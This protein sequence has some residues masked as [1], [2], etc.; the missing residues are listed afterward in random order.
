MTEPTEPKPVLDYASPRPQRLRPEDVFKSVVA[1][2][3]AICAIALGLLC[4]AGSIVAGLHFF[5]ATSPRYRD[6]Y[7]DTAIQTLLM[8]VITIGPGIY[9]GRAGIRKLQSG[10]ERHH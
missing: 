2:L 9:Y 8:A 6:E 5:A 10:S 3:F 7:E 4:L 1:I